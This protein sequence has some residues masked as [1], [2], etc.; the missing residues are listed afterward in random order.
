MV[1]PP[2]PYHLL[3]ERDLIQAGVYSMGTLAGLSIE[4]AEDGLVAMTQNPQPW[5]RF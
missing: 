2:L 3:L 1:T 4:V 5:V